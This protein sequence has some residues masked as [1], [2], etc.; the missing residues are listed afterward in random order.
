MIK[1]SDVYNETF[2]ILR[3]AKND[4]RLVLFLGAGISVESG[5]P[6]WKSAI[7]EIADALSLN[8]NDDTLKIPQYYFN[9]R[10]KKE[11]TEFMR[12]IF[13]Y[14]DDLNTTPVHK[15]LIKLEPVHIKIA[16]KIIAKVRFPKYR[17][18]SLS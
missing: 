3:E 18:S 7:K 13:K 5:L 6:L 4:K 9:A 15:A 2:R 10:G 1:K 8:E 17:T 14:G 12:K 16:S 11:Y